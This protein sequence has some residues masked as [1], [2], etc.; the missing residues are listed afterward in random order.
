VS[1]KKKESLVVTIDGPAGAG[2]STVSKQLAEVLGGMLLD[3]GGMYRSV[4]YFAHKQGA[5]TAKEFE[6]IARGLKFEIEHK[7]RTLLVN[8]EDLG[9]RLRTQEVSTM[10]SNVSQFKGVRTVLTAKQRKLGK[11]LGRKI[12]VVVEGRDIGTVVFPDVRFK[13]FV[14]ADPSVRAERRYHQLKRQGVKGITLKEILK[15]NQSRDKQDTHRKVA[16][17]KCP[18]DAV[19]VDTSEMAISQVVQFMKN[20]IQ[21]RNFPEG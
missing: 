1:S 7:T 6:K 20:H 10:A 18:K 19:V 14:T 8:G 21:A 17:L 11:E 12:P 15:Q 13:F 9:H 2:K 16:P 3:T 5:R 4:A